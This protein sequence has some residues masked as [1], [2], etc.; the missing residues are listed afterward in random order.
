MKSVY[1]DEV[2]HSIQAILSGEMVLSP[3]IGQ[4]LLKHAAR[5][6]LKSVLLEAGEK[7]ST[8]ELEILKLTARGMSNKDIALAL[9][10]NIRTVKAHLGE[11]FSKLGVAS[12][13]EAVIKG[14]RTDIISLDDLQ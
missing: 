12:R 1:T 11:I 13:T 10:V 5:Y 4:R 8:R 3:I 6:P 7:L 9:S 14:L 2:I